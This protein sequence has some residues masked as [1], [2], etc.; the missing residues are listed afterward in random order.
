M[1]TTQYLQMLT[2][3]IHSATVA[4]IYSEGHP[5]TRIIDIMLYDDNGIYFL[6]AK[7]KAF[8]QQLMEQQYISLSATNGKKDVS[9][10]GWVKAIGQ[11]K[12]AEIFQKNPYMQDIYPKGK[13]DALEV[14]H[15]YAAQGDFFDISLPTRVTRDNFTIGEYAIQPHGYTISDTCIG[16]GKCIDACPQNCI[17]IIS[18][19]ARIEEKHCLHCGRCVSFCPIGAIR[20]IG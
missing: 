15:I 18:I 11:D 6:T 17:D 7:G 1:Q 19:S 8:Y 16:C 5:I 2:E 3:E 13:R 4:T 9:L 20:K 10:H 12:L 14:F